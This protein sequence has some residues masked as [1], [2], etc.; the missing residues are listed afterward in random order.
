MHTGGGGGAWRCGG[1]V[2]ETGYGLRVVER[3][4][5][6]R[7]CGAGHLEQFISPFVQCGSGSA[8]RAVQDADCMCKPFISSNSPQGRR[9]ARRR[10]AWRTG[11]PSSPTLLARGVSWRGCGARKPGESESA[12]FMRARNNTSKA[13]WRAWRTPGGTGCSTCGGLGEQVASAMRAPDLALGHGLEAD[14]AE[15][16]PR[17]VRALLP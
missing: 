13:T 3:I 2:R 10:P 17:A 6:R 16:E 14:A 11:C 15:V 4:V 7:L 5:L 8:A 12:D 1:L 9:T